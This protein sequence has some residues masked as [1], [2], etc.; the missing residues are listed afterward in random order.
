MGHDG[1]WDYVIATSHDARARLDIVPMAQKARG[2]QTL[3]KYLIG[4]ALNLQCF[5]SGL[6]AGPR[7]VKILEYQR[8]HVS[9]ETASHI[10]RDEVM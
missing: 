6:D 9:S 5:C 7:F 10:I 8:D 3:P 1:L 2:S 4:H